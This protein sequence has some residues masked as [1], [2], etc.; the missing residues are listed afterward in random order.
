MPNTDVATRPASKGVVASTRSFSTERVGSWIGGWEPP[1]IRFWQVQ[2]SL[3]PG[4]CPIVIIRSHP[5][6]RGPLMTLKNE[7]KEIL[8]FSCFLRSCI[9][10][11]RLLMFL[12]VFKVFQGTPD[13]KQSSLN[14]PEGPPDLIYP[15]LFPNFHCVSKHM[16]WPRCSLS[17]RVV[18][19]AV[20]AHI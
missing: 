12:M 4:Y 16:V 9:D 18:L 6:A 15:T 17:Q 1:R 10:F 13:L 14:P 19:I 11:N 5:I 2:K 3:H 20:W 7:L 8:G